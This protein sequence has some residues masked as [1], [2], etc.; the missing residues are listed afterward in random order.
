MR[1]KK[2][3]IKTLPLAM[4]LSVVVA[5]TSHAQ[6]N[7]PKQPIQLVVGFSAGG[8][9]DNVARVIAKPLGEQL[10]T[11]VVVQNKPGADGVIG[12]SSVAREKADGH[13]LLLAPTTHTINAS[14]YKNL[15]YDTEKDFTPITMLGSSPNVIAV[16]PSLPVKTLA[17]F[18]EYTKNSKTMPFYGSTSSVTELATEMLNQQSNIK[19]SKVPYKGAGQ[20]IPALLSNEVQAMVSSLTTL[21]PHIQQGN[22][23]ALAVTSKDRLDIEPDLPTVA[24]SGLP[25]YSASTWYGIFAPA[26]TPPEVVLRINTALKTVLQD[27]E[28]AGKLRAQGMLIEEELKSPDQFRNFVGRDIRQWSAIMTAANIEKK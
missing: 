7:Y 27:K 14:Y 12:A 16:H 10:N 22:V 1:Q 8:P 5:H 2:T 17:E 26:G 3:V 9:A 6:V 24:E 13:T 21:L 18:I 11:A 15:P 4:A 19:M 25:D 28:V 20:A 23:R